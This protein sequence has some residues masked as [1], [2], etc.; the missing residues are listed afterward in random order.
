MLDERILDLINKEIDGVIAPAEQAMLDG[1]RAQNPEVAVMESELRAVALALGEVRAVEAPVSLK[2]RV[3]RSILPQ[4]RHESAARRILTPVL[5]FF[6]APSG[7]KVAYAFSFGIVAGIAL[8]ALYASVRSPGSVD[9]ADLTGTMIIGGSAGSVEVGPV[10]ALTG[11][12]VSGSIETQFAHSLAILKVNVSSSDN[13]RAEF[14]YDPSLLAVRAIQRG[15][16][17]RTDLAVSGNKVEVRSV[18]NDGFTLY[19]DRKSPV[20]SPVRVA[21][22]AGEKLVYTRDIASAPAAR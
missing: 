4:P 20:A 19:L 22:Y 12:G 8:F 3:M 14:T 1:Y 9:T 17:A 18:G 16:D 5:D 7:L 6:R 2:A 11:D 15:T 21:L 13:I 10:V